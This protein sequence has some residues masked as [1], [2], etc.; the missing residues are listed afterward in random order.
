MAKLA[1]SS[2]PKIEVPA[3][4]KT[5]IFD[6]HR[7]A[8]RG[9][10]LKVT[11][12]GSRVFVLRYTIDGRQ[13]LKTIGEWPTWSLDAA[14][15]EAHTLL[16]GIGQGRDPLEEKRR[17][18]S[19]PTVADLADEWLRKHASGLKSETDIRRYILSDLVPALGRL[20]VSDVGRRDVIEVVEKKAEQ[21]PRAAAQLL[22]YAKRLLEYATDRNIIPLNPV[23]GLKPSA[24]KV[25]GRRDPL[26][27]TVR[28]RVLDQDEV[29]AFWKGIESSNLH[30]LTALALKMILV[31]GQRPGEVAAMRWDEIEGEV[32]TI[33]A[34]RRG[35]TETAHTV[36][37]TATALAIL[38]AARMEVERLS[39]RRRTTEAV[40][41]FETRPGKPLTVAALDRAVARGREGERWTPHDLRRTMRTGLSACKVRPDIAELTIGHTKR[42]IVA[43]Y[44]RH[45]FEAERREA[46]EAW[47]TWLLQMVNDN[48]VSLA[49]KRSSA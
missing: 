12:A 13:R 21:A 28:D 33:P 10:A 6:D 47:E 1:T 32:W 44:D 31:T 27:T 37:M 42:G 20:K 26:K 5:F 40:Y 48:V 7:D 3:A 14:R 11:A 22:L 29:R 23:A 8:P 36:H 17:R 24:I 38:A 30:K 46:L 35:K 19:E 18:R 15:K 49:G 45:G 4:G 9:F 34:Q 39:R 25:S 41:V 2:I 16:R 43:V